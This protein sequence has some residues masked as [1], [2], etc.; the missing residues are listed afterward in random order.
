MQTQDASS[1]LL[2]KLWPWFEANKK[3]IIIGLVVAG[4]VVA[5]A[6][7]LSAQREQN[8]T[9]AGEE[10]TRLL[11]TAAPTVAAPQF[12]EALAKVAANHPGTAAA[13]RAQLQAG[14]TLFNAGLYADAQII[15]QKFL[16]TGNSG[17]AL[18]ATA[19]L[20]VATC[21]EALGKP[22]TLAAYQKVAA[23]YSGTISAEVAKQAVTRLTP[24]TVTA[25]LAAPAAVPAT[26]AKS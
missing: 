6:T 13:E 21:L 2:F 5:G 7:Y 4:L 15:F 11:A 1:E 26:P 24:K 10:M 22:E 12:A 20:G 9:A 17:G 25:P 18:A 14:A 8:E 23:S 16:D 19:Q 3:G